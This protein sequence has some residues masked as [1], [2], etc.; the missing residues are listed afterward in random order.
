MLN[1]KKKRSFQQRRKTVIT[2]PYL[3]HLSGRNRFHA[4]LHRNIHC[5]HSPWL[6]P[7]PP[8]PS[9]AKSHLHS[10]ARLSLA[11]RNNW[12]PLHQMVVLCIFFLKKNALRRGCWAGW[13]GSREATKALRL[14][15]LSPFG[16]GA[17][18]M[19]PFKNAALLLKCS[20]NDGKTANKK[21]AAMRVTQQVS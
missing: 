2:A 12:L 21:T 20:Q 17:N 8:P 7:P 9:F 5:V 13:F 19:P 11:N 16:R 15:R 18:H 6:T 14:L 3:L 4:L 10:D 1:W